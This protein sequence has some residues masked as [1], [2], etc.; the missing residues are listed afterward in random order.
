MIQDKRE[1]KC[2][3]HKRSSALPELS[4]AEEQLLTRY[5]DSETSLLDGLLV[6]SLKW[7]KS[8][9]VEQFLGLLGVIREISRGEQ[10]GILKTNP[11]PVDLWSKIDQRISEEE[12]IAVFYGRE[13]FSSHNRAAL[14]AREE[15]SKVAEMLGRFV[16][17]LGGGLVAA[18]ATF[19]MLRGPAPV[20]QM[21]GLSHGS[22]EGNLAPVAVVRPVSDTASSDLAYDDEGP[23]VVEVDWMR[24]DGRVR[25]LHQPQDR[26]AL[27]WV[28]KRQPFNGSTLS[29]YEQ[30]R[31][32][33]SRLGQS[34]TPLDVAPIQ[35][36]NDR[37]PDSIPV[38]NR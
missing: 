26:S 21:V 35:V 24:S 38:S 10:A 5:F 28:K 31:L 33:E 23:H 3:E 1:G 8:E 6:R 11:K 36:L 4:E 32:G 13:R 29:R 27:I 34:V 20:T 7:R 37:I 9:S 15:P 25:L 16:W 30:R 17:S 2:A 14:P 22:Q 19:V 12:R 18:C